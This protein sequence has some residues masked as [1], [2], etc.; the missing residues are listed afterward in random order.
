MGTKWTSS[1]LCKI[2][3]ILFC[4]LVWISAGFAEPP[5]K[6]GTLV[7]GVE[8]EPA[9]YDVVKARGLAVCDAVIANTV[10]ERL[11]ELDEQGT[12][13]P[14]LGLSADPS[15]DRKI[16]TIVLRKGVLFHDGTPFNADA[17]VYH[18]SRVLN[19]E[20]RFQG[21]SVINV[22][23]SVEKVDDYTIT[24]HLKHPWQPFPQIL[25]GARTLTN[26]MPSPTAVEKDIQLRSPVGTGPF[27]FKE[28]KS[29]DEFVVVRNPN[30]RQKDKPYIDKIIFKIAP[31]H[32]T[33]FASLKSGDMD[34]IWM[35][36]G[37]LIAQAENDP[38]LSIYTGEGNG[39]EIFILNTRKP[40]LDHPD[41]RRAIA[42]A[43]N[44]EACVN[45]S[46]KGA[47]PMAFHPLDVSVGCGDAGYRH[48]DLA[49]A[50]QLIK[51][52][53][54]PLEL[55]C[56]HSSTQRGREQGEIL[57]QFAKNIDIDIKPVGLA[58][59]PIIKKVYTGDYEISTW[60]IPSAVDFG[61][62][63]MNLFHS[64]SPCNVTGYSSP[65]MDELLEKQELEMDPETR[66]GILCDIVK[67]I[68]EDAPIIYRGGKRYHVIAKTTVQ[69]VPVFQNGILWFSGLW[70]K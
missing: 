20:N 65:R 21:F 29:G 67:L 40:P 45:M 6:G 54:T 57:Q 42:H 64:K 33:R 62:I 2:G 56:L 4:V 11:F 28:W 30:Y 46:Y 35:D 17:V 68:N 3:L 7:F 16:W 44:Q 61:P 15:P 50:K 10:M 38:D 22:I 8:N 31:D 60:R 19:T 5:K 25:S 53:G 70:L 9:G 43:W 66:N 37:Q 24:F 26:L 48:F 34:M 18:W 32:Q 23:E 39:A 36:R 47:I 58:F 27:M 52:H 63:F 49:K 12:L 59:G 14:A 41:V 13:V 69:G 51:G 55:E 1:I